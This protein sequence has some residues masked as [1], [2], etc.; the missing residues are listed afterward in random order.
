MKLSTKSLAFL[1]PLHLAFVAS[2]AIALLPEHSIVSLTVEDGPVESYGAFGFFLASVFF[3]IAW[4][5]SDGLGNK[6]GAIQLRRNAIYLFLALLFFFAAGEE[7]SWGQR[8]FGWATP[9]QLAELNRQGETNFHNLAPFQHG[10]VIDIHLLF[11]VFWLGLCIGIP[12]L[13]FAKP[14]RRWFEDL[15]VPIT[16]L[17]IGSMLLV[18]Y[19]VFKLVASTFSPSEVQHGLNELKESNSAVVFAVVA[20]FEA[21]RATWAP[22]P[23]EGE[24]AQAMELDAKGGS[25]QPD[26][27]TGAQP[28]LRAGR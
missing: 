1:V 4:L 8:V 13:A 14:L 19:V 20:L 3:L 10:A 9:E 18:N 23:S 16:S 6:L 26:R 25:K 24:G 2:Y 22:R 7:I 5:R 21:I 12:L 15:G 11:N 27:S 17:W 28:T